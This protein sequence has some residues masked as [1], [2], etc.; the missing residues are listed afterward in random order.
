VQPGD[1]GPIAEI[2]RA[3]SPRETP[4]TA[5]ELAEHQAVFPQGQFVADTGYA[6]A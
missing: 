4:S 1:Y 2:C 3:V 6:P 5:A